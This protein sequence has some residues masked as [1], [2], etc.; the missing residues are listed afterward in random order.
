MAY[1]LIMTSTVIGIISGLTV[2][3]GGIFFFVRERSSKKA[4]LLYALVTLLGLADL[5]FTFIS[6]SIRMT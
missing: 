3:G 1:N 6:Y 2:T 4:R 5:V